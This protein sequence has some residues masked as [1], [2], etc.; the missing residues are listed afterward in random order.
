MTIIFCPHCNRR[1]TVGFDCQD[2][3]HKCNSGNL[4]IDQDDIVVIGNWEDFTGSGTKQKQVV[5][6]QGLINV[7]QGRRAAIEGED[8]EALT[9]RGK[10]ASTHRQ[11]QHEEFINIKNERLN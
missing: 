11:R 7:L 2:Y 6:R 3:I 5:M 9:R 10:R 1:I 8:S 4:A